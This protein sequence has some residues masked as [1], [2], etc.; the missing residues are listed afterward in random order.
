M[1]KDAEHLSTPLGSL[2]VVAFGV[3]NRENAI[4]FL[5]VIFVQSNHA[6][7]ELSHRFIL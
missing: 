4:Q 7:Y 1:F 3:F 5:T 2:G 6:S